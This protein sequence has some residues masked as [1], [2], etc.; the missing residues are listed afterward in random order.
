[1]KFYY[2]W[3]FFDSHLLSL[4][5]LQAHVIF[6]NPSPPH[7]AMGFCH[8]FLCLISV[9]VYCSY[10]QGRPG[11][12]TPWLLLTCVTMVL[13]L[14]SIFVFLACIKKEVNTYYCPIAAAGLFLEAYLLVLVYSLR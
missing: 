4:I 14:I 11:L 12:I 3:K 2:V 1:M 6:V 10:S 9:R 8:C 5:L 7:P 13:Q